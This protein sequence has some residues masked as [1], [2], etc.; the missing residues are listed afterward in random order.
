MS[1]GVRGHADI[2]RSIEDW[3]VQSGPEILTGEPDRIAP[4]K[5]A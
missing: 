4:V 3:R 1:A 2:R 5:G